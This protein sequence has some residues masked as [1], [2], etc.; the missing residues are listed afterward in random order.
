MIAK[1]TREKLNEGD[2]AAYGDSLRPQTADA[3]WLAFCRWV[4]DNDRF[5]WFPKL[6][7]LRDALREFR[8]EPNLLAEA[9]LAYQRVDK[10]GEPSAHGGTVWTY[11]AVKKAC[12]QAAAEAFLEAG[13]HS[14][15]CTTWN[16][17][18]TREAFIA[19]YLRHSREVPTDRLLPAGPERKALPA[20]AEGF[21]HEEAVKILKGLDG[22]TPRITRPPKVVDLNDGAT[23]E[24]LAELKEQAQRLVSES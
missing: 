11:R 17:A 21:S 10:S 14:A 23:K 2:Y 3:E 16:E 24:R 12:G 15:F 9:Q 18:K 20:P 6:V 19:A 7:E 22:D 5:T 4:V 1:A 8:G 13:G